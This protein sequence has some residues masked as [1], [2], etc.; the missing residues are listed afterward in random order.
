LA[1]NKMPNHTLLIEVPV[2]MNSR[3][4]DP[5]EVLESV[6]IVKKEMNV[7]HKLKE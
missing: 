1:M 5:W 6:V 7:Q 2:M 4:V 3:I